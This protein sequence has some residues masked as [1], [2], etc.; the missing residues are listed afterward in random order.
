MCVCIINIMM[1][2]QK[3]VYIETHFL[4]VNKCIFIITKLEQQL[5]VSKTSNVLM[6]IS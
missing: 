3:L 4:N 2:L 6:Y 1:Y 5:F